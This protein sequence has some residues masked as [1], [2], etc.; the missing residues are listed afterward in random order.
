M[1][2]DHYFQLSGHVTQGPGPM[3][4]WPE[5]KMCSA[6]TELVSVQRHSKEDPSPI[7]GYEHVDLL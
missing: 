7:R 2:E 4:V 6:R 1:A 3:R 5:Y